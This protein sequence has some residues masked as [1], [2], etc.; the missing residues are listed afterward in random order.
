MVR[1]VHTADL[2]LNALRSRFDGYLE[3]V[4]VML[5]E[6]DRIAV[7]S[8]ADFLVVAGDIFAQPNLTN[9]DRQLLTDWLARVPVPVIGISGNHDARD[10]QIGNTCLSYLSRLPLNQHYFNDQ[11]PQVY[12]HDLVTFLLIPWHG[13]TDPEFYAISTALLDQALKLKRGLPIVAVAH[14][15]F[16]GCRRDD[17]EVLVTTGQ[18]HVPTGLEEVAW[19]ALGDMHLPQRLADNA[20]YSGSPHQIDFGEGTEKGCLVVTIDGSVVQSEFQPIASTP[21]VT[22][23]TL[24]ENGEWPPFCRFK[25][26]ELIAGLQLPNGIEYVVPDISGPESDYTVKSQCADVLDNLVAVLYRAKLPSELHGRAEELARSLL[27]KI[28]V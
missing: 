24:P 21:L 23:E 13:W 16:S 19:W 25:P 22:L 15:A 14:E 28:E 12:Q 27:T 18:P 9:P 2:H 10:H 3:R 4:D 5:E 6:L 20:Y 8:K 1:F 11:D 26:A 7:Q 17:G